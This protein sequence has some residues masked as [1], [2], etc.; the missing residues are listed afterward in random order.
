MCVFCFFFFFFFFLF[1]FFFFF[2]FFL[3]FFFFF[4]FFG[5][6][7]FLSYFGKLAFKITPEARLP[8]YPYR[9]VIV[10]PVID[11]RPLL[12]RTTPPSPPGRTFTPPNP[13]TFMLPILSSCCFESR[14]LP[15]GRTPCESPLIPVKKLSS[16]G[17][18]PDR[19]SRFCVF[20]DR[21]GT[22]VPRSLAPTTP[23]GRGVLRPRME[24]ARPRP[25]PRPEIDSSGRPTSPF[26]S[27]P[28][29]P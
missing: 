10:V 5:Q 29:H 21:R 11:W 19:Y 23:L 28:L 14:S 18:F 27:A 2:F 9:R 13:V 12:E 1:F 25:P 26:L 24:T 16:P 7:A 6:K 17:G 8:L 22:L 3:F 4:F 15:V 20:R